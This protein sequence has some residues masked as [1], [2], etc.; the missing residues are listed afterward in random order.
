MKESDIRPS[1]LISQ[2]LALCDQDAKNFPDKDKSIYRTCVACGSSQIIH[3]FSKSNFDYYSCTQCG[4]V[5]L[6]PR[7]PLVAFEN[8]YKNSLSSTYWSDV[9]FPSVAETRRHQI[10]KPRVHSSS[11]YFQ[12]RNFVI[13]SLLDVGSG[14]GIFLEEWRKLSPSSLLYA[15]EPSP[16]LAE[17]CRSKGFYVY[18]DVVEQ[19]NVPSACTVDLVVCFEV[20]ARSRSFKFHPIAEAFFKS[21]WPSIADYIVFFWF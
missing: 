17:T 16:S 14:Y 4:T 10:F 15:I 1:D 5:F 21:I 8:F 20:L 18:E 9:F 13:N 12:Q 6:N 3:A 2:Y 11:N 19:I 7:P